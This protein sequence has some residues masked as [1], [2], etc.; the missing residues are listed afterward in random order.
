MFQPLSWLALSWFLL[1]ISRDEVDRWWLA[2]GAVTGISLLSKYTIAFYLLALAPGILATPLRRS[3]TKPWLYAGAGLALLM[4][5]P[6][7]C[8]SNSMAGLFWKSAKRAAMARI[9]RSPRWVS[10]F[11][12]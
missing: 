6:T 4:V 7:F 11:S 10:F 8:G 5:A 1:R 2:F 3:F 9:S 12:S